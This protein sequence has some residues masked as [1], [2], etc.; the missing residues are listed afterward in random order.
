MCE[1]PNYSH[2]QARKIWTICQAYDVLLG[3]SFP[4][5]L[6]LDQKVLRQQIKKGELYLNGD[7]IKRD[8]MEKQL[9]I[10]CGNKILNVD[11]YQETSQ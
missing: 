11:F 6:S 4:H 10:N 2:V 9:Q 8:K 3:V 5:R 7:K 1:T